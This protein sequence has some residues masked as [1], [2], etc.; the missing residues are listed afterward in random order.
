MRDQARPAPKIYRHDY[1]NPASVLRRMQEITFFVATIS[2]RHGSG[3]HNMKR[4]M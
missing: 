2:G 1:R 4:K 3:K